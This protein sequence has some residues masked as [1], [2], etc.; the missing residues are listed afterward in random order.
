MTV[1]RLGFLFISHIGMLMNS[2][3]PLS[4]LPLK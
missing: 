2:V 3:I 1:E 4:E